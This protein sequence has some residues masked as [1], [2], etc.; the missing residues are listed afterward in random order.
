[1]LRYIDVPIINNSACNNY[2]LGSVKN[3]N[4]CTSSKADKKSTC[5]GDSGGP[6]VLIDND[7][8]ILIGATSFGII[9][10]CELGFPSVFTRITSYLD[11]IEKISGVSSR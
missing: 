11:W 1:M 10:G 9:F 3:T 7:D 5:N 6:L 2:Y 8:N 4:I